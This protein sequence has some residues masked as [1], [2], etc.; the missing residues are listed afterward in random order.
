M[1]QEER[2]K[3]KGSDLKNVYLN[4]ERK[5]FHFKIIIKTFSVSYFF[6]FFFSQKNRNFSFQIL[7]V[8]CITSRKPPQANKILKS[9]IVI[10]I[11]IFFPLSRQKN[12]SK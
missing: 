6:F 1:C 4:D 2:K 10:I 7:F 9:G 3:K 12:L 5:Q 8:C 11:I